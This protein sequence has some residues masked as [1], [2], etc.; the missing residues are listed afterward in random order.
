MLDCTRQRIAT[1]AGRL[2]L[3]IGLACL[4]LGLIAGVSHSADMARLRCT[5]GGDTSSVMLDEANR[6]VQLNDDLFADGK[7]E[8]GSG[9]FLLTGKFEGEAPG[10]SLTHY[11]RFS[12]DAVEFGK[13]GKAAGGDLKY[14][15]RLDR[16]TL[17]LDI[18]AP[19]LG[20]M[21]ERRLKCEPSPDPLK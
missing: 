15:G 1:I 5:A 18:S 14:A 21:T 9:A 20:L 11:V 3:A 6:S 19:Y 8:N 16:K 17:M 2:S 7:V 13:T 12:A 4:V 10:L